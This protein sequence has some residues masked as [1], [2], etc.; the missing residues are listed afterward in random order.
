MTLKSDAKFK[1]KVTCSFKYDMEN[2]LNFHGTNQESENFSSMDWFCS[3]YLRFELKKY[4][5]V[6]FL[7]TE[8]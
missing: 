4:S 6:I 2:F 8:Q 3:K 5:G 1:G 7:D